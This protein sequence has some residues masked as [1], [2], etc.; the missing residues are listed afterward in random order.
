LGRVYEAW[1]KPQKAI[2]CYRTE[3][4]REAPDRPGNLLR[5]RWLE[6][7]LPASAQADAKKK[8]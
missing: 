8:S 6:S 2:E 1:G 4:Q 3:V 7:V 5:A